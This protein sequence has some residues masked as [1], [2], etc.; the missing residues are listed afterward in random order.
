MAII[1]QFHCKGQLM[2]LPTD[3]LEAVSDFYESLLGLPLVRDQG[4]CRIFRSGPGAYLGFCNRGYAIP[5]DYRVVITLLIDDVDGAYHALKAQGVETENEPGLSERFNVYQFF[6]RD[7]N[8]YLVEV[9]RFNDPL[10]E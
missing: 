6:V 5:T 2:F 10:P 7:P 8:G 9:Q 3:D 1:D 4:L